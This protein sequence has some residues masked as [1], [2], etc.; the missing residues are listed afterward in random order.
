MNDGFEAVCKEHL[1]HSITRVR[2]TL[3][4]AATAATML[5]RWRFMVSLSWVAVQC[6]CAGQGETLQFWR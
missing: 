6:C 2:R 3:A 4:P 1:Q 5:N